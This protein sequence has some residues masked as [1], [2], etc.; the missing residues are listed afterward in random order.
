MPEIRCQAYWPV[1]LVTNQFKL[2]S[3]YTRN[4]SEHSI[5]DACLKL[6]AVA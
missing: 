2:D 4:Q 6:N 5:E 1:G 3:H